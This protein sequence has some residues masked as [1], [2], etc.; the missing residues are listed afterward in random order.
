MARPFR[1]SR[2][3]P[4]TR[5]GLSNNWLT[6]LGYALAACGLTGVVFFIGADLI[7]SRD[8][9][10]VGVAV[11]PPLLVTLGGCALIALGIFR[12]WWRRNRGLPPS[13]PGEA[14]LRLG[15]KLMQ[16]SNSLF[17]VPMAPLAS[18]GILFAGAGSLTA[19]EYTESNAFCGEMCHDVMGPEATVY[20]ESAHAKIAC[21]KCHV[22]EGSESYIRSKLNGMRQLSAVAIGSYSRPIPTPIHNRRPSRE[23]CESCH[24]PE[25]FI[26]YKVLT[27]TYFPSSGDDEPLRLRAMLKVGGGRSDLVESSGIH[28]HM[29]IAHKVEFVT[30]DKR[31]QDVAWV[32]M[33]HPDG[34]VEEF[35]NTE[36]PMS[37]AER[38][39]LAAHVLECIDCHSRPAHRFPPPVDSVNA[40]LLTGLISRELPEIKVE[41]VRALDGGYATTEEALAGI[42]LG[43][44]A[45]YDEN[46]PDV[47]E[48]DL[49]EL[50]RTVASLQGIY[51]RTIF[52]EMKADW[53]SHPD[54]IGHRDSPGCF[55]C[56]NDEMESEDG[57]TI[58]TDCSRCHV[59][60]AQGEDIA[61]AK[62][63]FEL[64]SAF[65]H[66]EDGDTLEEFTQCSDCHTGGIDLY[67]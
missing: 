52:P 50:E 2:P 25:R 35:R 42:D 55:R 12:E 56:H 13:A 62:A 57:E 58:F 64:G 63:N 15:G 61:V 44:R 60:L 5:A 27:R 21:V 6:I 34:K 8:G 38:D 39:K 59:I 49:D 32:R 31:R 53:S 17:L 20:Q 14:L 7:F 10:Y 67:E 24:W 43:L 33:T 40:G 19:V 65:V 22:G 4:E 47:L 51:Q 54:N 29:L 26:D 41:A 1:R 45:F 11:V 3:E 36:N 46:Y 66:P 28:Y 18:L 16:R 37:D 30:R 48:D 9:S 23:M